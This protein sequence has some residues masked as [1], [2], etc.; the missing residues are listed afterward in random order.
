MNPET[1]MPFGYGSADDQESVNVPSALDALDY[2]VMSQG[3]ALGEGYA[4]CAS[5]LNGNGDNLSPGQRAGEFGKD[6]LRAGMLLSYM[7]VPIEDLFLAGYARLFFMA[8]PELRGQVWVHH[9]IEQQV[10]RR[11]PGTFTRQQ[12]HSLENLRG[13]PKEINS[14]LHLSQIRREWNRFYKAHPT[15]TAE[16]IR[17]QAA[18]IDSLY[19]HEFMPARE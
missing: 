5:G 19:G 3:L 16:E 7:G 6:T 14:R 18:R 8:Y 4:H 12:I 17:F 9:A 13:I 2:F 11:Y 10:L 15:A 1:N